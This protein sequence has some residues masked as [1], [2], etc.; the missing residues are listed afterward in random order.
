MSDAWPDLDYAAWKETRETLHLW[1]QVLG[2]VRLKKAAPVNHWWHVPLYVSARGLT[3]SSIPD[4]DRAF[5]MLLD[6]VDHR[7]VVAC[8]DGRVADFTLEPM[9]VAEFYARTM[10]T[11]RSVGVEVRNYTTPAEIPGALPFEQDDAHTAYDPAAV[12]RFWRALVRMQ[13]VFETFRGR[14]LGKCSPV[15]FFWGSF[16]LALTRFSGRRAPEHPG[17][18]VMPDFI[19]REAYSHEVSSAGFW[20]GGEG[21]EEAIFYAYAYPAPSGFAD[22]PVRPPAARYDSMMSEFVLPYAAVRRAPSPEAALLEFLQSTY[23]AVAD[24]GGWDRAAL[25]RAAA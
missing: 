22:A 8:S 10:Q 4:G 13:A 19:T 11:L 23:E 2:K 21:L 5:E 18:A 15:H 16:D 17:V 24:L 12:G 3:T 9:S 1:T 20:P 25:E 7:L 14:W 6:F